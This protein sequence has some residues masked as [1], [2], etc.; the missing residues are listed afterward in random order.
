MADAN[1]VDLWPSAR[2][3]LV[4]LPSPNP[5]CRWSS[6]IGDLMIES[7]PRRGV[8]SAETNRWRAAADQGARSPVMANRSSRCRARPAP[9]GPGALDPDLVQLA[10]ERSH[11]SSRP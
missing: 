10:G 7:C 3:D 5:I 9:V 4:I 11:V 8:S 1:G 6:R 2:R